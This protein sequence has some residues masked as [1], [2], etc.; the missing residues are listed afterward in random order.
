VA[1]T[2]TQGY[3]APAV[4]EAYL[5]ARA[6]CEQAGD[7]VQLFIVL[8]GLWL[9]YLVRGEIHTA[10]RQGDDCLR[11]AQQHQAPALL[12]E[13][14]RMAGTSH[15]FLGDL[16]RAWTHL[17]EG[18][19]LY[20]VQQHNALL[21][22]YGQDP[23]LVCLV[24]GAWLLWLQGY[25][26][27][28]LARLHAALTL[29]QQCQ[30]PWCMAFAHTFAVLLHQCRRDLAAMSISL[31]VCLPLAQ[32][33]GFPLLA[34]MGLIFQ[35][36]VQAESGHGVEG[37]AQIRQGLAAYQATGAEL[38]RPYFLG[39]LAQAYGRHGQIDTALETLDEALGLVDTTGEQVYGAELYWLKG[40]M[41]CH[42]AGQALAPE[43]CFLQTL[44]VSHRQGAKA[45]ELRAALSLSRL[46]QRQ[47]QR[48]EARTLLAGVSGWFTEG[49]D[50][51]ELREA[52]TLLEALQ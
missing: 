28:A 44:E 5:Q 1:L 11:L 52:K 6:Y 48:A 30:H 15:F 41:L 47:G 39:L 8:H 35:G 17:A 42:M 16:D 51:P 36:W 31:E 49:L 43:T 20:E 3:A 27:Q 50:V 23:G 40:E 4:E 2:A 37:I 9:V 21:A 24:Y 46:W 33:Q 14:H 32:Q 25:A 22:R 7:T 18:I 45:W 34:A 19:A 29:A 13:A 38:S 10:T 12:L 26:D